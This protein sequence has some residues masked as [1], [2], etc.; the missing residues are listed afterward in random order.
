MASTS[1]ELPISTSRAAKVARLARDAARSFDEVVDATSG[2]GRWATPGRDGAV[3]GAIAVAR[4]DGRFDVELHLV[5]RPVPLHP[6]GERIRERL[7]RD[8]RN[9]GVAE[10]VGPVDIAFEDVVE[11]PANGGERS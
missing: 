8:A 5:A 11:T 2:R 7:E 6:L 1:E 9:A 3:E 10:L 4:P